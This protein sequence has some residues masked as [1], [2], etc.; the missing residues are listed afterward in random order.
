MNNKNVC[1]KI[2]FNVHLAQNTLPYFFS[3]KHIT[4]THV[5][6]YVC[7]KV[8]VQI[9][10]LISNMKTYQLTLNFIPWSLDT[11]KVYSPVAI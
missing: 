11:R 2:E 1:S 4:S 3:I 8:K 6:T 10:S 5:P 7:I 9:Y